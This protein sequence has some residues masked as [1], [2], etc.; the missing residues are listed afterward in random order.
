MIDY[1]ALRRTLRSR[2]LQ[3]TNLSE[4]QCK[5]ENRPFRK[6][7]TDKLWVE[8]WLIPNTSHKIA[9][10]QL[11]ALGLVQYSVFGPAGGGTEEIG[12]LAKRIGDAFKDGYS[13]TEEITVQVQR[14]EVRPGAETTDKAS[15]MIPVRVY[16]RCY[17]PLPTTE[18]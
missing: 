5:W 9:S 8:E 16:W 17:A 14:C 1:E 3:V 13:I 4:K 12:D 10:D 7:S 15:Y 11:G 6:R 18:E 2:L